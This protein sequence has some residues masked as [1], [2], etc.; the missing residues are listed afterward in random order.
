VVKAYS[1]IRFSTPEQRKGDSLRRQVEKAR[2][3]AAANGLVLDDT[4]T[5]TDLGTSAFRGKNAQDGGLSLFLAAIDEG[6]V[7]EGA[8]LLIEN[9]DRLSRQPAIEAIHLLQSIVNRG[10]TVVTLTDGRKYSKETLRNDQMTLLGSIFSMFRAHE[11]SKVKGERL[12][13]AWGKKKQKDAREG[14]AITKMLPAWLKVEGDKIIT[15][16]EKAKVVLR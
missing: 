9:F 7:E 14:K 3:Y 8:F 5:F 1:Y 16:E 11:E 10:V 12:R 6:R 4:L 2:D 15:I 13:A